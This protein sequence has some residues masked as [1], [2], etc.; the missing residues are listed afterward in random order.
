MT[1]IVYKY[2]ANLMH[3]GDNVRRDT[4]TLLSHQLY[5]ASFESLNDPFEASA[6]LPPDD[7]TGNGWVIALKQSTYSV[8]V[9]SLVKPAEGE[10]FPKN[11]LMWSHYA[12]SHRGFCIEYDLD[13]LCQSISHSFNLISSMDVSYQVNRPNIPREENL[14]KLLHKFCGTKSKAWEY[15]NEYRLV[16]GDSGLK[17]IPAKAIKA[18]YFG[19]RIGLEERSQVIAGLKNENVEFYQMERVGNTYQLRATKLMFTYDYEIVD[20]EHLPVVDNYTILYKSPNKDKNTISEFV[21][22]FRRNFTKKT[23]VT[24]ID[25]I[26][27]MDIINRSRNTWSSAE[28][29]IIANHWI[30]FSS[31]EAPKSIWMYPEK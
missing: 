31:F 1:R 21:A 22:Y 2:R 8:G 6:E 15:E 16:F 24:V 5:A 23:N 3:T 18:I 13:I 4:Q 29:G 27:V 9:Y 19:L 20:E 26:R 10:L 30:A 25:D 12:D 17:P 28:H 11:E 7:I 14:D